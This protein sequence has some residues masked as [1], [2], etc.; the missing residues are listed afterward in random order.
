MYQALPVDL[1]GEGVDVLR[2]SREEV[3]QVSSV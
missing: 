2:E 1:D 3:G